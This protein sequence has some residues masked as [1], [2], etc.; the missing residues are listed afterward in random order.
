MKF[1]EEKFSDF[2]EIKKKLKI[3]KNV[4]DCSRKNFN[5]QL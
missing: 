4:P 2:P 3:T 5:Q 1:L